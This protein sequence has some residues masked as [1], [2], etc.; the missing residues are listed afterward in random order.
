MEAKH[1]LKLM[2]EVKDMAFATIA[3]DGRPTV[4]IVDV[5]LVEEDRLYFLTARGKEFYEQLMEQKFVAITGMT[6]NWEMLSLR[7]RVERA[8]RSL[9][10]AIFEGNPSMK[11]VYSGS[12]RDILDVFCICEGQ[13]EYFDLSKSPIYRETILLG[14]WPERLKGYEIT[15]VCTACGTCAEICPQQC[16]E[17]GAPYAIGQQS[18]L[19]CGLCVENCPADAIE[20]RDRSRKADII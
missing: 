17:P 10:D 4:R 5:M 3:E 12:S 15:D 19:H 14:G 18:C 16:I 8:D 1:F 2:R 11:E 20:R 9:L 7:G 13:G 6:K